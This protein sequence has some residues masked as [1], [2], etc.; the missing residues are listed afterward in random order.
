MRERKCS[1]YLL[2]IDFRHMFWQI[3]SLFCMYERASLAFYFVILIKLHFVWSMKI[4]VTTKLVKLVRK[5]F[6]CSFS[7]STIPIYLPFSFHDM[8]TFVDIIQKKWEH[9]RW[10]WLHNQHAY[11]GSHCFLPFSSTISLS[12]LVFLGFLFGFPFIHF[13]WCKTHV[14]FASF[15]PRTMGGGGGVEQFKDRNLRGIW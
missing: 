11:S 1:H 13:S 10:F 4:Y 15:L 7:W 2:S 12:A 5:I 6:H 8:L 3:Y 14:P 9:A